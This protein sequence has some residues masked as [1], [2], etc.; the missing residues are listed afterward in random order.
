MQ[1]W[2]HRQ[3]DAAQQDLSTMMPCLSS[4]AFRSFIS[5]TSHV[6]TCNTVLQSFVP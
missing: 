3:L 2:T 4:C 6:T 1:G 5:C